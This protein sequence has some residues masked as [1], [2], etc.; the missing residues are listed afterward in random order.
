M[1]PHPKGWNL[2]A[3]ADGAA[4]A[5]HVAAC[6]LRDRQHWPDQPLG[7]ATGRTMEPVYGALVK[8]V[9]ALP[10]GSNRACASSG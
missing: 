1:N 9:Q 6:L 10:A 7:L 4:V 8:A 2:V 5:D 3:C